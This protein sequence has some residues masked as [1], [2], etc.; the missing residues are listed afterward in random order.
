MYHIKCLTLGFI[1]STLYFVC[2]FLYI[3]KLKRSYVLGEVQDDDDTL[4][5]RR[6]NKKME[7][8]EKD[9]EERKPSAPLASSIEE[10]DFGGASTSDSLPYKKTQV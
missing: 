5:I 9:F 6:K 8:S 4:T 10:P 3:G 2:I 7:F 1:G